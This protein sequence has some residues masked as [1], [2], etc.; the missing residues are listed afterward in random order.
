M[1]SDKKPAPTFPHPVE[2]CTYEE[3]RAEWGREAVALQRRGRT[4]PEPLPL[5][6][7]P[8]ETQQRAAEAEEIRAIE[9]RHEEAERDFREH[10][11]AGGREQDHWWG[12]VY[13]DRGRLLVLL[14]ESLMREAR[15]S[16][17]LR[18]AR[19]EAGRL[20]GALVERFCE[21]PAGPIQMHDRP[22]NLTESPRPAGTLASLDDACDGAP[23]PGE[24]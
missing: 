16:A 21:R 13:R 10:I 4:P 12:A 2:D 7:I 24:R 23:R 5:G 6:T 9:E 11:A 15:L 3:M 17:D 14:R 20:R 8:P 18:E 22:D 1:S 19:E